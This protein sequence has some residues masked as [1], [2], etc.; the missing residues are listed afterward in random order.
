MAFLVA[1][2]GVFVEGLEVVVIVLTLGATG[3]D[4]GLAALA[5]AAALVVVS[6]VAAVV[7]RQL[8]G[9]PESAMKTGV[10]LML[11]SFGTFWAGEGLG[12]RWPG[13]GPHDPGPGRRVRPVVLAAGG[14]SPP[15]RPTGRTG[16]GGAAWLSPGPDPAGPTPGRSDGP[17]WPSAGSGGTS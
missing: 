15:V 13:I 9:V 5:A 6:V 2:K 14:R 10:G 1:F 7:A 3:H 8:S 16:R 4:L 11:V 12:V 17:W